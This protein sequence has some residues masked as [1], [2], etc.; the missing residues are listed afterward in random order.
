MFTARLARGSL[1]IT[2]ADNRML[3]AGERFA[4]AMIGIAMVILLGIAGMGFGLVKF[5]RAMTRPVAGQSVAGGAVH[6]MTTGPDLPEDML[7]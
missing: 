5:Y 7:F 6:S 3:T 2:V 4:L 1:Y